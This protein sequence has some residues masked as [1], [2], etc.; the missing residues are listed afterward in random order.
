V[1]WDFKKRKKVFKNFPSKTAPLLKNPVSAPDHSYLVSGAQLDIFAGGG[2]F[3]N[4]GWRGF[5]IDSKNF[6]RTFFSQILKN[7]FRFDANSLT[8][9]TFFY[10]HLPPRLPQKD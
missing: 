4:F 8:M 1:I 10:L 2:S 5:Q 6:L 7:F 9:S 3:R